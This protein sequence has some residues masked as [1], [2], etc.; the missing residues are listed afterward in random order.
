[1]TIAYDNANQVN[2]AGA[3]TTGVGIAVGR[4]LGDVVT[5]VGPV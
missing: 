4:T 3:T 2:A 5:G 1:M